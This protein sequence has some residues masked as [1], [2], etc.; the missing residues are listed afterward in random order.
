VAEKAVQEGP[1]RRLTVD[2]TKYVRDTKPYGRCWL[3]PVRSFVFNQHLIL[4]PPALDFLPFLRR[5]RPRGLRPRRPAQRS[6][7]V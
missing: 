7:F 4:P 6:V 3:S 2:L 1:R 5:Q